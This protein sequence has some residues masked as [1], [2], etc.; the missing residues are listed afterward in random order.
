MGDVI[1]ASVQGPIRRYTITGIA[2]FG[3]VDSLG[4]ATVAVFDTKTAQQL[5]GKDGYDLIAVSAKPG[6]SPDSLVRE[7][8]PLLPARTEV[9]TGAEQAKAAAKDIA[10]FTKFIQYFLLAFGAVALFVGA[11]VIFNTLSITIAQRTRELATLRTLGASRR[12]VRRSVLLEGFVIGVVASALGLALGVGLAKGLG[13]LMAAMNLDLPQTGTGVRGS[14]RDRLDD[15]R[16]RRHPAR[17]DRPG[18]QGDEGAADRG[19]PR[20]RDAA[21]GPLRPV[22]RPSSRSR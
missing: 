22:P 7:I 8:K 15:A 2:K 19:R 4:G 6:V 13:A 18:D 10:E 1:G 21:E 14:H 3:S 9:Q 5:L 17:H 11:F 16:D 20:G 12:Q